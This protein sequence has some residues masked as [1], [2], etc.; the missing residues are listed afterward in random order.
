M[1]YTCT[2]CYRG[3]TDISLARRKPI[4]VTHFLHKGFL[5]SFWARRD[6][7]RTLDLDLSGFAGSKGNRDKSY[8]PPPHAAGLLRW[9]RP[10]GVDQ[11]FPRTIEKWVW[12][13]YKTIRKEGSYLRWDYLTAGRRRAGL[14]I[15]EMKIIRWRDNLRNE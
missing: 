15:L 14:K 5:P 3:K 6:L 13:F 12:L 8:P 2:T 9:V 7:R 4:H 11:L 10:A 1:Y